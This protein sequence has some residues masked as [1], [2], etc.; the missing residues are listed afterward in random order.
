MHTGHPELSDTEQVQSAVLVEAESE[1]DLE[2]IIRQ[3]NIISS[4]H[5]LEEDADIYVSK[6]IET[7]CIDIKLSK[8]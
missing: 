2:N 5:N 1:E 3:D 4:I 7:F 8:I 6:V